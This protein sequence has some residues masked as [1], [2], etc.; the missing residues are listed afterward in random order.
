MRTPN[1]RERKLWQASDSRALGRILQ[2]L[3]LSSTPK[4][5]ENGNQLFVNRTRQRKK[6]P[7]G[8]SHRMS[9]ADRE[10]KEMKT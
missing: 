5:K 4:T 9:E 3:N 8:A 7:E 2:I 6:N 1:R 10:E